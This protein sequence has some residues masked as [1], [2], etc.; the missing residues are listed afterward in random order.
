MVGFYFIEKCAK[1][2]KSHEN[3]EAPKLSELEVEVFAHSKPTN[4]TQVWKNTFHPAENDA[5]YEKKE[6]LSNKR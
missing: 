1:E 4:L 6:G 5:D 3:I 2:H